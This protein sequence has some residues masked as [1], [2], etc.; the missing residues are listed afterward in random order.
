MKYTQHTLDKIEQVAEE[1]GY[2][3]VTRGVIFKVVYCIL[4]AKK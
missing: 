3:S 4:Q 1:A 2:I